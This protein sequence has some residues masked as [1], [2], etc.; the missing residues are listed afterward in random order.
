MGRSCVPSA[1]FRIG[2][3]TT[4]S[5][6]CPIRAIRSPVDSE[7]LKDPAGRPHTP[8]N[9]SSLS[10]R[11]TDRM[12][13]SFRTR[14]AMDRLMGLDTLLWKRAQPVPQLPDIPQN[15]SNRR[16]TISIRSMKSPLEV[17]ARWNRYERSVTI[18]AGR[19]D[20]EVEAQQRPGDCQLLHGGNVST[21]CTTWNVIRT[22]L[23][24]EVSK[25]GTVS[26]Q[27]LQPIASSF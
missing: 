1:S 9:S 20:T 22:F 4:P 5:F 23:S 16:T 21:A 3:R 13:F 8:G 19:S 2:V 15:G 24:L 10:G 12:R 26:Y 18:P 27:R 25:N 17:I 14:T 7:F 11:R 6:C